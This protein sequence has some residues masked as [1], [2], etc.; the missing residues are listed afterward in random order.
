MDKKKS[1]TKRTVLSRNIKINLPEYPRIH[2]IY[3]GHNS[4]SSV[5][6]VLKKI[7]QASHDHN[8]NALGTIRPQRVASPVIATVV[9]INQAYHPVITKLSSHFPDSLNYNIKKQDDFI[10]GVSSVRL[11]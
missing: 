6:S 10:N 3:L 7:G 8:D 4:S 1:N 9:K 2:E 11:K 5:N